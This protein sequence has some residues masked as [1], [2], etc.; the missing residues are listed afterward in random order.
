MDEEGGRGALFIKNSY[1]KCFRRERAEA[2]VKRRVPPMRGGGFNKG[3]LNGGRRQDRR[4]CPVVPPFGGRAR[5]VS[6]IKN[7]LFTTARRQRGR[8][9]ASMKIAVRENFM[10]VGA[11]GR[12]DRLSSL[13]F[14]RRAAPDDGEAR[15]K[16][17]S[18]SLSAKRNETKRNETKRNE[19]IPL[20]P[21]PAATRRRK[22]SRADSCRACPFDPRVR[23]ENL[24]EFALEIESRGK[25][26]SVLPS[27]SAS[28][29]ISRL[30]DRNTRARASHRG[31]L[32]DLF[33]PRILDASDS[34]LVE[35]W[36]RLS[37]FYLCGGTNSRSRDVVLESSLAIIYRVA[38]L[39]IFIR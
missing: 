7:L 15:L 2:F 23:E 33:S 11:A 39:Q 8:K 18:D 34:R 3:I 12:T 10:N 16:L 32:A 9:V 28:A 4:S 13:P 1:S 36:K 22:L 31:P 17:F 5:G 20:L 26:F 30:R 6:L 27:A 19:K 35:T 21:H 14:A 24:P 37:R 29:E 25:S 38:V